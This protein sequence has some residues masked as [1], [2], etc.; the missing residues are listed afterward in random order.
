MRY[1][2]YNNVKIKNDFEGSEFGKTQK[3]EFSEFKGNP[4][5]CKSNIN[6]VE[7]IND[8]REKNG[9]I[10]SNN[11]N[12][13]SK[14]QQQKNTETVK[15]ITNASAGASASAVV[16]GAATVVVIPVVGSVI[17]ATILQNVRAEFAFLEASTHSIFYGVELE[18][19]EDVPFYLELLSFEDNQVIDTRVLEEGLNKDEFIF[20][21]PETKY[22]LNI[23]SADLDKTIHATEYVTTLSEYTPDPEPETYAEFKEFTFD[24]T[25]NFRTNSFEISMFYDD[26]MGEF[27]DFKFTLTGQEGVRVYN[28]EKTTA[29]QTL[30]GYSQNQ[31]EVEFDFTLGN[32]YGYSLTYVFNNELVEVEK[33]TV[34][35]T[36]NSG[37]KQVFRGVEL[38]NEADFLRNV[39]YVTLDF[40][41]DL[42]H[43]SDFVFTLSSET[44]PTY[45]FNLE[46]TTEKQA[47]HLSSAIQ[48]EEGGN[49][50]NIV[51]EDTAFSYTLTYKERGETKSVES[52]QPM[53]FEDVSGAVQ[54]F[55][56]ITIH[57]NA[58]FI[59]K[60]FYVTL[61]FDNDY[62]HFSNF[63]LMLSCQNQPM[64]TFDLRATTEKQTIYLKDATIEGGHPSDELLETLILD[65]T[66][67]YVLTYLNKGDLVQVDS[68]NPVTF[69]DE[70][71]AV[72]EFRG[73][74]FDPEANY[75][76]KTFSVTLDMDNDYGYFSSFRL[77]IAKQGNCQLF[78]DLAPTTSKQTLEV[79]NP[80][81]YES[82][83]GQLLTDY[84]MHGTFSYKFT[85]YDRKQ[86][87]TIESTG[88]VTFT[89][90]SGAKQEFRGITF[91]SQADFKDAIIYVTLDFDNELNEFRSFYVDLKF[92]SYVLSFELE[93]TTEK[94]AVDLHNG[95]GYSIGDYFDLSQE[96]QYDLHY[97][98]LNS[99]KTLEGTETLTFADIQ[100]RVTEFRGVT[101]NPYIDQMEGVMTLT[102][103]YADDYGYL[104]NFSL[105]LY[106]SYGADQVDPQEYNFELTK[107]LSAQTIDVS[108]YELYFSEATEVSY[109]VFYTDARTGSE[110]YEGTQ[111]FQSAYEI[112]DA[113]FYSSVIRSGDQYYGIA[114]INY[115]DNTNSVGNWTLTISNSTSQSGA[116]SEAIT[117]NKV[118]GYQYVNITSALQAY[119]TANPGAAVDSADAN[120][121]PLD[122]RLEYGIS[123]TIKGQ[124]FDVIGNATITLDLRDGTD[125]VACSLTSTTIQYSNPI[126]QFNIYGRY[127]TYSAS[128]YTIIFSS[129]S[130]ENE[131]YEVSMTEESLM[132]FD[133]VNETYSLR[134]NRVDDLPGLL[135][136]LSSNEVNVTL[137]YSTYY[138]QDYQYVTVALYTQFT[139]EVSNG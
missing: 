45:T 35:F 107:T 133:N 86:G 71:G 55:R 126:L 46:T 28:L 18:E 121:Y 135:S 72:S 43:L 108:Q 129:D 41:N 32:E 33:G 75:L 3:T 69:Y 99:Y 98:E 96:F 94:Q 57:E 106:V 128:E 84:N 48:G 124:T 44:T 17:G 80:D 50:S 61:D 125:I 92:E 31:D 36:D 24:K 56:G 67:G 13:E 34:T 49:T 16:A 138:S 60:C 115:V 116:F 73:I 118:S 87:K 22:V 123:T 114:Y 26:P 25:A 4:E 112:Y 68:Q 85:Y 110:Y 23:R 10:G 82:T 15:Q 37:A 102:L 58:N 79:L 81:D 21:K 101:F 111:T 97:Y 136:F 53:V 104:S 8:D 109:K 19:T 14:S 119:K 40:D 66:F 27:S 127:L 54:E 105:T 76:N 51:L 130:N 137:R 2:E 134:L 39:I 74:V 7:I 11:P 6:D 89:D 113:S 47:L 100:N 95:W 90:N 62:L 38:S 29:A 42:G 103:D 77:Q 12:Y 64:M 9:L 91:D 1:D 120:G 88:N 20:L 117:L 83:S 122:L 93:A 139:V 131:R 65:E 70:S 5:P 59:E 30:S 78:Y 132:N 63:T 52:E